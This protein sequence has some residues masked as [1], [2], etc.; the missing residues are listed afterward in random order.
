MSS[1]PPPP[2][3]PSPG[4]SPRGPGGRTEPPFPRWLIWVVLGLVLFMVMFS[5]SIPRD[6]GDKIEYEGGDSSLMAQVADGKVESVE[7]DNNDGSITG[8]LENGDKFRSNGPLEPSD[9]DR[10]LFEANG[11]EVTFVTPQG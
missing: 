9:A 6:E 5:S 4:R 8:E 10:D 2:P 7:W 1:Q 3:P 11:V